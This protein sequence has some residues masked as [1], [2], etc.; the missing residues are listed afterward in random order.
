M[1]LRDKAGWTPLHFASG[2][3]HLNVVRVLVDHGADMNAKQ[4]HL[5]VPLYLV[6]C[7]DHFETVRL[8]LDRGA[9]VDEWNVGRLRVSW[10][11]G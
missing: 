9:N 3:G 11:R 6:P 1:H 7:N 5:W 8:L 4:Q 10:L 2:K